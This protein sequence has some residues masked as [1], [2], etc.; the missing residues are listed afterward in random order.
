ML[1]P[2][3]PLERG[4]LDGDSIAAMHDFCICNISRLLESFS[5]NS[6][7]LL[8]GEFIF[9]CSCA[10]MEIVCSEECIHANEIGKPVEQHG[11]SPNT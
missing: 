7:R 11:W 9:I 5:L 8:R 2:V 4:I 1:L 3:V 10:S 6:L